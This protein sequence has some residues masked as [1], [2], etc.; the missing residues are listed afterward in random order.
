[1]FQDDGS[2]LEQLLGSRKPRGLSDMSAIDY[3]PPA[4]TARQPDLQGEARLDN[5]MP[6]PDEAVVQGWRP[7]KRSTLGLIGD[8]LLGFMGAQ[9]PVFGNRIRNKNIEGA[10]EGFTQDPLESIRRMRQVDPDAAWKMYGQ[11]KDDE[12]ADIV[13]NAAKEK[14]RN[15]VRDRIGSMMGAS[16]P[17][18]WEKNLPLLR[19]YAESR[20]EDPSEI[21]DAYDEDAINMYRMGGVPVDDQLDNDRDGRYKSERLQDFDENR[22]ATNDRFYQGQ[23]NQDRRQEYGQDRQDARQSRSIAAQDRRGGKGPSR[24]VIIKDSKGNDRA[25]RFSPDGTKAIGEA[26]GTTVRYHVINGKLIPVKE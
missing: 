2:L 21:P 22:D 15:M 6:E 23:A 7:K 3:Q 5:D 10:M 16:N 11:Y 25:I 14:Q 8:V 18:N 13:A 20:G 4:V 9:Q 1:M 26:N 17:D 19:R 24:N 12:R